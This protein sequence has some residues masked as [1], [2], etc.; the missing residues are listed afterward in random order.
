MGHTIVWAI[1]DPDLDSDPSVWPV[2]TPDVVLIDALHAVASAHL[3]GEPVPSPW[4]WH[5]SQPSEMTGLADLLDAQ[6]VRV[7]RVAVDNGYFPYGPRYE[8]KLDFMDSGRGGSVLEAEFPEVFVRVSL[9]PALGWMVDVHSPLWDG[10]G[11]VELDWCLRGRSSA[12][13]GMPRA[14]VSV[15]EIAELLCQGWEAWDVESTWEPPR[16]ATPH[17]PESIFALQEPLFADIPVEVAAPNWF[18]GFAKLWNDGGEDGTR[19]GRSRT[20]CASEIAEAVLHQLRDFGFGD[21]SEGDADTPIESDTF[22]IAWHSGRRPLSTSEVQ[23]LNGMAA[24]AGED[25]PKRLIVITGTGL[26][27]PASD[28]ANHA[29]AFAFYLDRTSGG[30]FAEN[31]RAHEALLPTKDPVRRGLDP[32]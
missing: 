2:R 28:F 21:L 3:A 8:P 30:L 18:A 9:K 25:V 6:G 26:T 4:R 5:E 27:R 1:V 23:R 24:A 14:S 32:W 11:R 29:K 19:P 20:P 15:R 12:V 31:T 13:P 16:P 7:R 17:S 10:W 22:H